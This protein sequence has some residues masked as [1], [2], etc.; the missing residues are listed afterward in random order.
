MND[1]INVVLNAYNAFQSMPPKE[2]FLVDCTPE[3]F[4]LQTICDITARGDQ[5]K[6]NKIINNIQVAAMH[7]AYLKE[8]KLDFIDDEVNDKIAKHLPRLQ[9]I[10]NLRRLRLP[11][12]MAAFVSPICLL[13]PKKL[14]A[15]EVAR[16][17]I[18]DVW[19]SLG[20]RRPIVVK[21]IED[22][23]WNLLEGLLG[24][25]DIE[26]DI[27]C[28]LQSISRISN[29]VTEIDNE[30]SLW[31]KTDPNVE[32]NT[33]FGVLS[34]RN[35]EIN[36]D[37]S[38]DAN[39]EE[40]RETF[41]KK[42]QAE[43]G[44][45]DK[46][47]SEEDEETSN[48]MQ[49]EYEEE[50]DEDTS[51][52]MQDEYEEVVDET[53]TN[54]RQNEDEEDEF[55][56]TNNRRDDDTFDHAQFGREDRDEDV[57]FEPRNSDEDE[58]MCDKQGNLNN[59]ED[60]LM[61][62]DPKPSAKQKLTMNLSSRSS[63]SLLRRKKASIS[64]KKQI[65]QQVYQ[66]APTS[67][68]QI[69]DLSQDWTAPPVISI[70][71]K[72]YP[73]PKLDPS[74]RL[75][76]HTPDV[77]LD[78][79]AHL[80]HQSD[81]CFF[82]T[83]A[84]S[85]KPVHLDNPTSSVFYITNHEHFE[86]LPAQEVQNIF[87]FQHII[88]TGVPLG[89]TMEFDRQGLETLCPWKKPK[90]MQDFSISVEGNNYSK[91]Q[92]IGSLQL[93]YE[94]AHVPD[95][96]VLNALDFPLASGPSPSLQ[97]AS[98]LRA[99][100]ST[101]DSPLSARTVEYPLNHMRWGLAASKGAQHTWH[102]DSMG[103]GTCVQVKTG[104]KWWVVGSP[105]KGRNDIMHIDDESVDVKLSASNDDIWD[106]EAMLLKPGMTFF[107]RPNTPHAVFTPE[108]CITY[109]SHF[110]A[111]STLRETCYGVVHSFI[112]SSAI[113]NADNN[114]VWNILQRL[115]CYYHQIFTNG[116]WKEACFDASHI[117]DV[118]SPSGVLDLYTFMV[119]LELANVFHESAY[120]NSGLIQLERLRIIEARRLSRELR[121]WVV[122]NFVVQIMDR[123]DEDLF[124][125]MLASMCVR[126]VYYLKEARSHNIKA[127]SPSCT[128]KRMSA[129]IYDV[130]SSNDVVLDLIKTQHAALKGNSIKWTDPVIVTPIA[131]PEPFNLSIGFTTAG[132]TPG[133]FSF[134]SNKKLPSTKVNLSALFFGR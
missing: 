109:G 23:L 85:V 87:R 94:H 29:N 121:N 78:Y 27:S 65:Q 39:E 133:D 108:N 12:I 100:D 77:Y 105:K 116:D 56:S 95:G 92:V 93:L 69:I 82:E 73:I 111:T 46:E 66:L 14:Y 10:H 3:S 50:E 24:S 86:S 31:F 84:K 97:I 75:F 47:T 59:V 11:L 118:S 102:I 90:V 30:L 28:T 132:Y 122:T 106:L 83:I 49:D 81:R 91:R 134:F 40:D 52:K 20:N 4:A 103:V 1:W 67:V 13:M 61:D 131:E 54:K 115:A 71:R 114:D 48:K 38:R 9:G 7:L 120:S 101:M 128:V 2:T 64:F 62:I 53:P 110:V 18:L 5:N 33:R 124:A 80:P 96:R 99:W 42:R 35:S 72:T 112:S 36:N 26:N 117:P 74:I 70:D 44:E 43:Y 55:T 17:T 79:S 123:P 22:R 60:N 57:H 34:V 19:Q 119:I 104:S 32:T 76:S 41:T 129:Q 107:M 98:D 126:L 25:N 37:A 8:G 88:V 58:N 89:R 6:K 68:H 45:E 51:N 21:T 130:I 127:T 113:T 63:R 125:W 15:M 16:E